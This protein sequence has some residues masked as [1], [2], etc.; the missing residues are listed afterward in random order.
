LDGVEYRYRD[1]HELRVFLRTLTEREVARIGG[2]GVVH[3]ALVVE[4]LV[5][6]LTAGFEGVIPWSGAP[7]CW[8]YLRDEER[9]L[10]VPLAAG[11]AVELT[12]VLVEGSDGIVR[13]V[14]PVTL[15]RDFSLALQTAVRERSVDEEEYEGQADTLHRQWLAGELA[16][17]AYGRWSSARAGTW[18]R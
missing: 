2:E 5:F 8:R 6:T 12:I 7:Y 4:P 14:H 9:A 13:T 1:G 17:R 10:P 18:G 15:S 3:L 11:E 16:D